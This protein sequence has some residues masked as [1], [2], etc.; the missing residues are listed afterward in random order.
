MLPAACAV[1]AAEA[2]E[3]ITY[4]YDALGRLTASSTTGTVNNGVSTGIGYDSAGNRT[5]YTVAGGSGPPPPPGGGDPPASASFAVGDASATEGGIL[6]FTIVKTGSAAGSVAYA[7][8]DGSAA[9]P[10]DYQAA[11]GP[12]AFAA[13]ETSKT[14]SVTTFDDT[15]DENAE[16]VA[17]NLS[18]ASAGASIGDG[19]GIGTIAD[20]DDPAA[21]PPPPGNISPTATNNRFSQQKCTSHAYDVVSD[22]SDQDGDTPLSLVAVSPTGTGFFRQSPTEI[23]FNSTSAVGDKSVTYTIRDARGA[24]AS[25]TLTVN[26]SGGTCGGGGGGIQAPP[27][28]PTGKIGK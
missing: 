10:G 3:T 25:A 24:E 13:A 12:L 26:V 4:S 14:V 8:A 19:Q 27:P 16:T 5:T 7:T 15:L 28:P 1:G 20:N 23:L 22:D 11:G 17:L 18:G 21:P 9:A 6:V 2:A